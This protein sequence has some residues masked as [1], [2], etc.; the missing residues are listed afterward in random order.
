MGM[1]G[2]F[3]ETNTIWENS[4][5]NTTLT[6][7]ALKHKNLQRI[8]CEYDHWLLFRKY[9]IYGPCETASLKNTLHI[10]LTSV[11]RRNIF[12]TLRPEPKKYRYPP[13]QDSLI[14]MV[15]FSRCTFDPLMP[16]LSNYPALFYNSWGSIALVT[17]INSYFS[18]LTRL[19]DAHGIGRL[20]FWENLNLRT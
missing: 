2:R 19:V 3:L 18:M 14:V 6:W 11:S 17:E 15:Y 4:P 16:A 10:N 5:S 20:D 7:N 1:K 8:H 9:A 13:Q 12:M